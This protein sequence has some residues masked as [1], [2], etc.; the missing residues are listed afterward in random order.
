MKSTRMSLRGRLLSL[1]A[2]VAGSGLA[3][4]VTAAPLAAPAGGGAPKV[5]LLG[6]DGLQLEKLQAV[7]PPNFKRLQVSKAYTGGIN[8][9]ASQQVT[10]SGPGWATILTGVWGNKHQI[11]SNTSDLANPQFPSIFKRLR[12]A[13]PDAKIASVTHWA[14]P[15]TVFFR[16]DV[17]GNDLTLS[18][19]NDEAVTAKGVELVQQDYD[20]VFLHLDDPDHFGHDECFGSEYNQSIRDT[21]VRLGRL[22]NAVEQS[23]SDWLVLVTTDHGRDSDGCGHGDQTRR[24]KTIFIA[25]NKAMNSEFSSVVS[26]I[27]NT[28]FSGLYGHLA[29]TS[30]APTVLRYLGVEPQVEWRLDGIPLVGNP[31]V[32]KLLPGDQGTDMRWYADAT[33][34][35]DVYRNGT[36]LTQLDALQRSFSDQSEIKGVVDYVLVKD[37]T[38]VALRVNKVDIVAALDWS[39]STAYFF[40]NDGRY[41][42]YGKADDDADDGYPADTTEGAWPGLGRYAPMISAAFSASGSRSYFFLS[43]GT[44][45]RYNNSEDEADA[46]YPKAIDDQSWPG[47]GAYATQITAALRWT[48]SKVYFFLKNGTY[49]RYD[50]SDDQVDPGYPQVVNDTTWPGLGAYAQDITSAVKW[51]DSQAYFFLTKQRYI[52]YSISDDEAD[53]GYPA[54]VNNGSWPGLMNP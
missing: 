41:I 20:L 12:D 32:R 51:S 11:V 10:Y 16:N 52:R 54:K 23:S 35:V 2:L 42:R 26:D 6:I 25:S 40:R 49:L 38:P 27:G 29:Q 45:I 46:G 37:Q 30:I 5:L 14:E 1:A 39:S 13:R 36:L 7:N 44:Y 43:N 4:A 53:A 22:L 28:E 48:G 24:E 33:G 19:L 34:P 31:G 9:E 15:N 3:L 50:L 17:T 21:D 47:L 18:D 8:R